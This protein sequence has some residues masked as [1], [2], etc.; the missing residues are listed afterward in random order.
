MEIFFFA[1]YN[2]KLRLPTV[3]K[4]TQVDDEKHSLHETRNVCN[5]SNS[6]M[7]ACLLVCVCLHVCVHVFDYLN[8]NKFNFSHTLT[9]LIISC[10]YKLFLFAFV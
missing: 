4:S 1:C 7:C 2:S 8:K 9:I 6:L 5:L 3:I 10:L